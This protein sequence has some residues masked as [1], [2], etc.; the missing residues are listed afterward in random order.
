MNISLQRRLI[1]AAT[2]ALAAGAAGTLWWGLTPIDVDQ[3][4]AAVSDRTAQGG[5]AEQE[6]LASPPQDQTL[7][8][9]RF[10]RPLQD[11]PKP[12]PPKPRAEPR[13]SKPQPAPRPSLNL[14]VVGTIIDQQDRLAIVSD[15]TGKFDVKAV[16]ESLELEP[17]GVQIESIDAESVVVRY[18]GTETVLKLSRTKSKRGRGTDENSN[19]E[20]RRNR[21]ARP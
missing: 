20:R 12:A 13:V 6:S 9:R 10:Q 18:R 19:A 5:V 16:G 14:S 4:R 1:G 17:K 11:P 7:I 3:I 21:R 15:A 2:L 8:A